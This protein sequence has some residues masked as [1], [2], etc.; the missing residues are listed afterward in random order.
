LDEKQTQNKELQKEIHVLQSKVKISDD[1]EKQLSSKLSQLEEERIKKTQIENKL[2]EKD[3]L[4]KEMLSELK[5][6]KKSLVKEQELKE[7]KSKQSDYKDLHNLESD[8]KNVSTIEDVK[9]FSETFSRLNNDTESLF[10]S[11]Y[12]IELVLKTHPTQSQYLLPIISKYFENKVPIKMKPS[13][14]N[15][16]E[17]N[18]VLSLFNHYSKPL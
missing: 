12:I 17:R 4:L 16:I 13:K 9:K 5:N 8:L 3:Q 10:F 15:G 7:L 2:E 18:L 6:V 11:K 14:Y 1:Q